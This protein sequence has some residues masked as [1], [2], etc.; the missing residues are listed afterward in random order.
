[1]KETCHCLQI[2]TNNVIDIGMFSNGTHC[3]LLGIR[4]T[5]FFV[6]F[7][8]SGMKYANDFIFSTNFYL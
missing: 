1:M 3:I 8:L 5:D 7:Y 4:M 6:Y 2:S